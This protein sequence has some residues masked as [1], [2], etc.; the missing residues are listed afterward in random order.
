MDGYIG[1]YMNGWV[2]R[3]K[4]LRSTECLLGGSLCA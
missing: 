1:G 3:Y 4:V 2:D